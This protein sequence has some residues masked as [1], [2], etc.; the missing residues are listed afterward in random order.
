[1]PIE[2][3]TS[4]DVARAVFPNDHPLTMR[5]AIRESDGAIIRRTGE[6]VLI[7]TIVTYRGVA[8]RDYTTRALW[9]LTSTTTGLTLWAC[10][11]LRL[12]S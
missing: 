6:S 4:R 11:E 12:D 8:K 1:M 3:A 9:E 7:E 5:C 10:R 2:P